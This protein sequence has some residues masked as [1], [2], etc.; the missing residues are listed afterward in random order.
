MDCS[1]PGMFLQL[2]GIQNGSEVNSDKM[3]MVNLSVQFSSVAKLCLTLCDKKK[4]LQKYIEKITKGIKT[5]NWKRALYEKENKKEETGGEK[6]STYRKQGKWCI[7][8]N[9]VKTTES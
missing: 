9:I 1:L 7:S 5:L 4:R 3:H 8:M 2:T 6:K